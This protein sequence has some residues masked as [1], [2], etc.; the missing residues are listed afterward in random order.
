[1]NR[2]Y[3]TFIW[4]ILFLVVIDQAVKTYIHTQFSL[5]ETLRV[6]DGYFNITYVRNTGAAFG[7]LSDA[8]ETFRKLFFLIIPVVAVVVIFFMLKT[9]PAED[10]IQVYS[11]SA[12]AGGALGNYVDRLKHGFVVDCIDVHFKHH[13][14]W[15]AFN[16]A[17]SAIVC[18]VFALFFLIIRDMKREKEAAKAAAEGR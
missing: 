8:P 12:I 2:K 17:D 9:T 15:P 1:M 16:I 14:T 18:G 3:L 4:V 13:Y 6:I 10:R 7:M 5:G 11:L